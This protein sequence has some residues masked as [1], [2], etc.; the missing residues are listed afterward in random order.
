MHST[1]IETV[2]RDTLVIKGTEIVC[3]T[4]VRAM[5]DRDMA[6]INFPEA[7]YDKYIAPLVGKLDTGSYPRHKLLFM[8]F[9]PFT[10]MFLEHTSWPDGE[11]LDEWM[12]DVRIVDEFNFRYGLAPAVFANVPGFGAALQGSR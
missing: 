8:R 3:T 10:G 4:H 2:G 11:K 6:S 12:E 7:E 1:A 5:C 9:S